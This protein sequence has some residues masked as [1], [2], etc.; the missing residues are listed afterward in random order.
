MDA[1]INNED[2]KWFEV[3]EWVG[4]RERDRHG[5]ARGRE[6]RKIR[7]KGTDG[8]GAECKEKEVTNKQW[9][10]GDEGEKGKEE[11]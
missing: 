6:M 8:M 9:S 7:V 5:G 3:I 10:E 1:S 4:I 2:K 11:K